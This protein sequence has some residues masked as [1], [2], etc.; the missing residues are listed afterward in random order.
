MCVCVSDYVCVCVCATC[1]LRIFLKLSVN[2]THPYK[3][4]GKLI[5]LLSKN[6]SGLTKSPACVCVCV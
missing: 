4:N 3:T 5:S 2:L 6:E 1:H